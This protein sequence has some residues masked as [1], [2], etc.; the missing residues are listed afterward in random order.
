MSR[1]PN[2]THRL[3]APLLLALAVGCSKKANTT[4]DTAAVAVVAPDTTAAVAVTAAPGGPVSLT[5]AS[6]PGVG[7]YL[8]DASGRAVYV[9]DDGTGATIACTGPCSTALQP[10]AGSASKAAGDTALNANLIGVTTLPDGTVQV[11]YAGKPLYYASQDQAASSISAQ[12][13]RQGNAT[14]YLV[15]PTGREIKSKAKA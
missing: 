2:I 1:N 11:T 6:K 8:T 10:V 7:V 15:S 9:L 3:A 13:T 12:G 4:L 14:S 5:V